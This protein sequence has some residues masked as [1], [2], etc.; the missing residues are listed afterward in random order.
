L[1][2]FSRLILCCYFDFG[3]LPGSPKAFDQRPNAGLWDVRLGIQ[4]NVLRR[5]SPKRLAFRNFDRLVFEGW[6]VSDGFGFY[7]ARTGK[8]VTPDKF[9]D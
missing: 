5:K 7:A 9:N 8:G 6:L 1:I 2:R 3:F 4:L